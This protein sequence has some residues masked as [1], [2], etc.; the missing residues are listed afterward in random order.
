MLKNCLYWMF[1]LAKGLSIDS[2]EV[3]GGRCL[4]GSDGNCVSVR[5]KDYMERIMKKM[6]EIIIWVRCSI[7][8]SSLCKERVGDAG[9]K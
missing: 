4:R 1:R 2:K 7:G 9:G 8:S 3:E 6:I 5:R